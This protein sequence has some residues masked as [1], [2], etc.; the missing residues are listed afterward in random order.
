M[1][2]TKRKKPEPLPYDKV[3][4][5][6]L[7]KMTRNMKKSGMTTAHKLELKELELLVVKHEAKLKSDA[8]ESMFVSELH[9]YLLLLM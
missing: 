7:R 3:R 8:D 1:P 5:Q 2:V 9:L 6:E 4:L